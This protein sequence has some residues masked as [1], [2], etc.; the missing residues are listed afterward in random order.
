[1]TDLERVEALL[2]Q[3]IEAWI[4]GGGKL[5]P[6]D[7]RQSIG[8]IRCACA[9]GTN[10]ESSHIVDHV[11]ALGVGIEQV[12]DIASGFDLDNRCTITRWYRLGARLRERYKEHVVMP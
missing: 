4:A 7:Y 8:D 10:L 6:G 11:K 12:R 5:A 9:L 2:T 3:S 1:M